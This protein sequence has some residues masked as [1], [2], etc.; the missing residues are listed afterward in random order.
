MNAVTPKALLRD[1]RELIAEARQD[2]ARQVNSALVLL[3][4]RV[5]KRIREDVLKEKRVEYG[6]EILHT[7]SAKLVEEFG[8][9]FSEKNLRRMVQFAEAFPKE[10]IVV[11]LLRGLG[12]SHFGKRL[13]SWN[14]K[15]ERFG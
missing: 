12:W 11:T 5:G 10:Q 13:N 15:K 4:W 9:G 14:S 6:E 7:V 2:V 8:T 3:Y 1:L